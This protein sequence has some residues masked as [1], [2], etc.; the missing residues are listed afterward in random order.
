MT[1]KT[2]GTILDHFV[3][4]IKNILGSHLEQIILY[5]SYA[6]GDYNEHSDIDIMIL[7]SLDESEKDKVLREIS[8]FAFD[9]ELEHDILLSPVIKNTKYFK[10]WVNIIPFFSNVMNEGVVLHG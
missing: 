1:Q 6:R 4:G 7:V 5:G 10:E 3:D 9:L 2:V 8:D